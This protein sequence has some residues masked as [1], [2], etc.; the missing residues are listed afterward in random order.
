MV[1]RLDKNKN[2]DEDNALDQK[3]EESEGVGLCGERRDREDAQ[4]QEEHQSYLHTEDC[5]MVGF[6]RYL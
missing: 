3:T 5:G 4:K 6:S 2:V 1:E